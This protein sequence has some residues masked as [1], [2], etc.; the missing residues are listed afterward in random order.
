MDRLTFER[1]LAEGFQLATR[2][3]T[4][5][6]PSTMIQGQAHAAPPV[7]LA[8][9]TRN[10]GSKSKRAQRRATALL[11]QQSRDQHCHHI[12]P[13][14]RGRGCPD[15]AEPEP[16]QLARF[17]DA[18]AQPLHRPPSSPADTG[19]KAHPEPQIRSIKL[20]PTPHRTASGPRRATLQAHRVA[21][22]R[23]NELAH[24]VWELQRL[25]SPLTGPQRGD[26][27]A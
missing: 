17:V 20:M 12:A 9:N 26:H 8:T 27:C 10:A 15:N 23:Q 1:V 21:I 25:R 19:Q 11:D 13:S 4:P 7:A 3:M 18:W 5:T 14:N 16:A 24:Q 2:A 22:P 6:K